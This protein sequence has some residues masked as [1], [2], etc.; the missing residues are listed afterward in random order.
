MGDK[1]H[2]YQFNISDYR[3]A[4]AHLSNEED[5]AYRRLLDMYYD[6]EQK[7]P[8]DIQWVSRRLRVESVVLRDVLN[9]MFVKHEDGYFHERCD[10]V[11]RHYQAMAEKNRING[12]LG[13]RR[14][15]PTGLP[16]ET[17][18]EPSPKATNNYKLQTTN[19]EKEKEKKEKAKP[20]IAPVGVSVDVWDSFLAQRKLARAVVTPKVIETIAKEAAKIGWSLEMALAECSARGWRGFKS[21]W[22]D[23]GNGRVAN[24][25]ENVMAGLTR[26]LVGGG[27]DVKLLGN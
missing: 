24:K 15:K 16:T 27:K 23:Q 22:I 11:I 17:H 3:A 8:L 13:G 1:L 10:A 5:L 20:M 2:F 18:E 14:K 25:N 21:D 4:T 19:Q 12:R 6:S 7:I 26:G 9:D